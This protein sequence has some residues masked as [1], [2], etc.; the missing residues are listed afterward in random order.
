LQTKKINTLKQQVTFEKSVSTN[1]T[2]DLNKKNKSSSSKIKKLTTEVNTLKNQLNK[3][4]NINASLTTDLSAEKIAHST[5]KN[6]L[7]KS[8]TNKI[9]EI[10]TLEAQLNTTSQQLT[11]ANK[12]G[13][14]VKECAKNAAT[15]TADLKNAKQEI[16]ILENVKEKHDNI[17]NDLNNQLTKLKAKQL[18]LNTEVQALNKK[19]GSLEETNIKLKELFIFKDFEVNGVKPSEL[20]K[21]INTYPTPKEIKGTNTIYTVQF[22]VFMKEQAYST[23]KSLD[24]VWYETTEQ[25]T[26]VY[27]SGEFKN[28]QEATAHKNKVIALGYQNAFVVTLTK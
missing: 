21:Q 19:T 24:D 4:I 23:L 6:G 11:S 26:Y 8:V 16:T 2:N 14:L 15:L 22:G 12:N 18:E 3:T 10:K 1:L 7:S 25:G 5:T 9:T 20:T 17:V 13:A 27:L 28:P